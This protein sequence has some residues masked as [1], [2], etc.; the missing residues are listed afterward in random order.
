[1]NTIV[2][3][4]LSYRPTLKQYRPPSDYVCNGFLDGELY[5]TKM[6]IKFRLSGSGI[7][8]YSPY[9]GMVRLFVSRNYECKGE[10]FDL[11]QGE[12][13]CNTVGRPN[14]TTAII[15]NN[16]F[17]T[18]RLEPI[19]S[20]GVRY[21]PEKFTLLGMLLNNDHHNSMGTVYKYDLNIFK[22]P[23]NPFNT[24][25]P[26]NNYTTTK[27]RVWDEGYYWTRYYNDEVV[28]YCKD[29]G[30]TYTYTAQIMINL[31]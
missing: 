22:T 19:L 20:P 29:I 4:L 27:V 15:E 18:F 10:V 3:P 23:Y 30:G 21:P 9:T 12:A 5:S 1:M 25:V 13:N 17:V 24:L 28:I 11:L 2:T 26:P 14:T 16:S 31:S 8:F 7:L 6:Y